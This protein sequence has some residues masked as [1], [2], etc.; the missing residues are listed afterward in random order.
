VYA[1]YNIAYS[2]GMMATNVLAG[3]AA[4]WA[5]VPQILL[6]AGVAL[7]VCIPLLLVRGPRAE[8]ANP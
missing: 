1:V 2:V 7:L 3:A 6:G 5:S 8:V 4:R